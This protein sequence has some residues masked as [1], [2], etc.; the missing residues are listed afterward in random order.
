MTTCIVPVEQ[1]DCMIL[2]DRL[3]LAPGSEILTCVA[4]L[5]VLGTSSHDFMTTLEGRVKK[6]WEL[7]V[8]GAVGKSIP[9][10]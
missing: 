2:Q 4:K 10:R 6:W 9:N 3:W 1:A 7:I 5:E 8:L